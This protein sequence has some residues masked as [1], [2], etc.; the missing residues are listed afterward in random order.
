MYHLSLNWDLEDWYVMLAGNHPV[1]VPQSLSLGSANLIMLLKKINFILII[2]IYIYSL[3]VLS[4]RS[5]AGCFSLF[6]KQ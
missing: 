3:V 6:I 2:Y 5:D 1:W 4:S